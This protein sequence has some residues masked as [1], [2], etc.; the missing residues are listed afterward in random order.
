M[1][2][3]LTKTLAVALETVGICA[4]LIGIG[5]E[6][7]YEADVGFVLITAGAVVVATGS[8]IFAKLTR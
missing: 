1:L 2:K 5:I 3:G 4:A 7:Y 6:V 8:L